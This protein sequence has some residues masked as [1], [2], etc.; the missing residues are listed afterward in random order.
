MEHVLKT[1]PGDPKSMNI[2]NLHKI[3]VPKIQ[4]CKNPGVHFLRKQKSAHSR[5]I[6]HGVLGGTLKSTK[7]DKLH[8]I[9]VSQFTGMFFAREKEPCGMSPDHRVLGGTLKS[10]KSDTNHKSRFNK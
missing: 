6:D 9:H 4:G 3:H 1:L 8:K 10:M 7:N 2:D 5:L